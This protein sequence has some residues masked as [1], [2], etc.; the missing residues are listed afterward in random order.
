M[1]PWSSWPPFRKTMSDC[2]NGPRGSIR[3]GLLILP[4][5]LVASGGAAEKKTP[6]TLIDAAAAEGGPKELIMLEIEPLAVR[7]ADK[8]S[9]DPTPQYGPQSAQAV[10]GASPGQFLVRSRDQ[11][12][13]DVPAEY[14]GLLQQLVAQQAAQQ[15]AQGA[16]LRP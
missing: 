4:A 16:Y 2:R 7:R 10:Y 6:E 11:G 9:P 1:T 8:R 12:E 14:L 15:A 13:P 5:C 3:T